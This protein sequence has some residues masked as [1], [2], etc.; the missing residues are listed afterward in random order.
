MTTVAQ[1][2]V[3]TTLSCS[4][5]PR[6][7]SHLAEI[8]P[9]SPTSLTPR[10]PR[11]LRLLAPA[12]VEAP[13]ELKSHLLLLRCQICCRRCPFRPIL[14]ALL[15]VGAFL[16]F[17]AVWGIGSPSH[18]AC[19]VEQSAADASPFLALS[20]C[21]GSSPRFADV[22]RANDVQVLGTHNSYH[23][24]PAVALSRA[25][26]Y[27]HLSLAAQLDAG[28]RSVELDVHWDP[29]FRSWSVYHE[30]FV[31]AGSTC[32]CLSACL[33]AIW[34]WSLAH[35]GH[36]MLTLVVEPKYNIDA[37]NPFRGGSAAA[38]L[39]LQQA[40]TS[41]LP[42]SAIVTPQALQGAAPTM[43]AAL[44]TCG[45]PAADEVRGAII[46]VLDVWCVTKSASRARRA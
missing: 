10:S 8:L 44:S 42:K 16:C 2:R 43:R 31:D 13:A 19:R 9:E 33:A 25:W 3:L 26:R 46:L 15:I 36:A 32:G 35:P 34:H 27:T 11:P 38:I 22:L 6:I 23:I 12:G 40:V 29:V 20:A 1:R 39:S 24:K 14:L 7:R 45:W 21:D 28:A 41:R 5:S 18:A 30:P 17:L 4:R 37:L